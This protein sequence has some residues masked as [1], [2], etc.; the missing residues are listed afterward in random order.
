MQKSNLLYV[1]TK[2]ELGGAQKQL[3]SLI[4]RIDKKEYNIFL[5][6]AYRGLLIEDALSIEG[7]QLKRSIFLERSINPLKD[8]LALIEIYR[9]IKKNK[10]DII[11]T[12]SSK[13][14]ILG[15]WAAK[16]A[17]VPAIIHTI[18]GWPFHRWQNSLIR[19]FYILLE[20]LTATIAHVLIAVSEHDV[21][22]GIKFKIGRREKYILIR[23]GINKEEFLD[24]NS[25][26][27]KREELAIGSAQAVVGM[28]ACL[29]PQKSPQDY[30]K[31]ASLVTKVFPQT[32]FLLVG[33]GVLRHKIEKL[34]KKFNLNEHVTLTGWRK[35]IPQILSAIDIFVLTS[36]WEGLSIA[37]LEALASAKPVVATDTGGIQEIVKDN[38]NG[39]L[40][41]PKNTKMLSDRLI[42]LL[43]DRQLMYRMAEEAKNSIGEEF[44]YK[45][46]A[47]KTQDLY[48]HLIKREKYAS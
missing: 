3:L 4:E 44:T 24:Y 38:R 22:K 34:I 29:K 37:A 10:I 30:I 6:T 13:A 48:A 2:L 15:R 14:G 5:I 1:I 41:P 27:N 40:V 33:D 28:V 17:K 19:Q 35:D 43:R 25:R 47:D 26:R 8:L 42:T 7:L 23:Y 16:L 46:M 21:E 36:F 39:F 20:R 9:F 32:K 18:H 12:H 45:H 11:H 31:V